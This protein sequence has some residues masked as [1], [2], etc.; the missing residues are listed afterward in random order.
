MKQLVVRFIRRDQ[1][2]DL[3]E[4]ALLGGIITAAVA[5]A[6][7]AISGRVQTLYSDLKSAIGAS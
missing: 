1:G 5:G 3:I 7:L 6:I 2:Q 4:Y